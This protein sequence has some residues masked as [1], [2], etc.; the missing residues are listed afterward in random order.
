MSVPVPFPANEQARLQA[1][2][3]YAIL[4]TAAEQAYDDITY[5]ASSIC[6]AP[7]ALISLV[8][9]TRQ[10]FKSR[11]GLVVKQTR[12]EFSFCVHAIADPD[13]LLIVEDASKDPRFASNPMVEGEPQIRFYAGAPLVTKNGDALG[14]VC[15]ID[16][17]PRSLDAHQCKALRCLARQVMAQLELR[18]SLNMLQAAEARL[19]ELTSRVALHSEADELT[20]LHN[21]RALQIK[22]ADEWER[23]FR[24]STSLSLLILDVDEFRS[25]NE[26]FG[27]PAGDQVLRKV[28]Q[29]LSKGGR[30]SDMAA[31]TGG[32]V[33]AIVLPVTDIDSALQIAER[34]RYAIELGEWPYRPITVSVGVSSYGIQ[35]DAA[36]LLAQ[37]EQALVSAKRAGRNCIVSSTL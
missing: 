35:T 17:Q 16:Y 12:R 10:W 15:V 7:V 20:Q 36:S 27:Y 24:Y 37:A 29:L 18:K 30:L 32:D 8:D 31:R 3:D 33:F 28:A 25:Y 9:E 34:I 22:L 11:V 6:A 4:D 26:T 14:S 1:L 21:R 23:A 13:N 5:L 19:A 2:A